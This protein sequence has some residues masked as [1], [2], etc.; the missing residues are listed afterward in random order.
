MRQRGFT[1]IE[2]IVAALFLLIAGTAAYF[3]LQ[4]FNTEQTNNQKKVAINA[5]YY[6][7][8]EGFFPANNYYPEHISDDTL[9]TMDPE[10]LKDP[11]GVT[12][13]EADS[14]YRYEPTNCQDGKCKAYTLRATLKNE[15][16][17]VKENRD[18]SEEE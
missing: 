6:S 2:I 11:E 1:V 9:P 12:L 3:Q 7:L 16:D 15:D 8:E 14:A 18:R 4:K 5:I 13:G 10:L 17:F